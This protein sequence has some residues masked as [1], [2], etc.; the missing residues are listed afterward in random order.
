MS[1]GAN[2]RQ[3]IRSCQGT[4]T[5]KSVQCF[6]DANSEEDLAKCTGQSGQVYLEKERKLHEEFEH[7]ANQKEENEAKENEAKENEAK[8]NKAKEND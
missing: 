7:K 8:E 3:A 6:I 4:A 2:P 5:H 1:V